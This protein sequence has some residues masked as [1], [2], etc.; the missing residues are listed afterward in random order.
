MG[1]TFRT[2]ISR[3]ILFVTKEAKIKE[4]KLAQWQFN[5]LKVHQFIMLLVDSVFLVAF[6]FVLFYNADIQTKI[7]NNVSKTKIKNNKQA[8]KTGWIL[9]V[10]LLKIRKYINLVSTKLASNHMG[11]NKMK[12]VK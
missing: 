5:Y 11:R 12:Q 9:E 4:E 1:E 3:K 8:N 6:L 7:N 10:K 2:E